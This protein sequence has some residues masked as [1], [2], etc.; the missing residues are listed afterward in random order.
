[1][2]VQPQVPREAQDDIEAAALWYEQQREGLGT[3]FVVELDT[4]L[5]R[6][7]TYPLQ[8][9]IVEG[10]VRRALLRRFPYAVYFVTEDEGGCPAI[11]AV[12]HQ[13]RDPDA[14]RSRV[15]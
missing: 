3:R 13:H 7:G 8:F 2:G 5:D 10:P 9:P 15:R 12:L 11:L 4:V 14:W 6:V 1:M